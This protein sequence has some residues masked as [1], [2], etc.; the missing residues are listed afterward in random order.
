MFLA[1]VQSGQL[2]AYYVRNNHLNPEKALRNRQ[3]Y[4]THSQTIEYLD[5]QIRVAL[6][7]QYLAPD[8]VTIGGSGVPDPKFLE[9]QGV[10]YGGWIRDTW[11]K[12]AWYWTAGWIAGIRYK[13]LG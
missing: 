8:G 3:P 7:H 4:C 5:G 1:R 13:L 12:K 2:V 10:T 9:I 11:Y 6:V